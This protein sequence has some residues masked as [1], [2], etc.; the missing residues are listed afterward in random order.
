MLTAFT[1]FIELHLAGPMAKIA[2]QRHL[3]A[4]R[5]GIIA[6]L[7]L[8]IVGSFFLIIAF[9]PLPQSWGIYQFLSSNAATILLPYR[10]TMYIMSLYATF[11][12]GASLSK[13]YN[14]DVVSGGILSTIA[15]LLTFVPVNIPLLAH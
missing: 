15:F 14:L 13:T 7:P 12:I 11:G 3:R 2:N 10:M 5:D 4:I 6:T 8:I 1:N 9:P